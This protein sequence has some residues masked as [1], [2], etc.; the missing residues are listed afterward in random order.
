[1]YLPTI[2]MLLA[3]SLISCQP[4]GKDTQSPDDSALGQNDLGTVQVVMGPEIPTVAHLSWNISQVQTTADIAAQVSYWNSFSDTRTISAQVSDNGDGT[5]S[6]TA[7]LLGL[8]ASSTYD[9]QVEVTEAGVQ[10]GTATG[11][12]ST[13]P[14][15][16]ELP[17]IYVEEFQPGSWQ[18]GYLLSTWVTWPPSVFVVNRLGSYVW[19]IVEDDESED[20]TINT[21]I[22]SN[23]GNSILYALYTSNATFAASDDEDTADAQIV[24]ISLDG[25]E[26]ES[27]AAPYLHHDFTELPDGTLAWLAYDFHEEGNNEYLGDAIMELAPGAVEPTMLWSTW[28]VPEIATTCI[29]RNMTPHANFLEY[30]AERDAYYVSLHNFNAII[31]IQ[32][33]TAQL[34]WTLGGPLSDFTMSEQDEFQW[35]HGFQVLEDTS[36]ILVFD[37]RDFRTVSESDEPVL[38]RVIEMELDTTDMTAQATWEYI[39]DPGFL[40]ICFGDVTRFGSG[41]TLVDFGCSGQ[42]DE[43]DHDGNLLW[44]ATSMAGG[45]MGYHVFKE[46]LYQP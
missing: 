4:E 5:A 22:F 38:S 27:I 40:T 17:G 20:T 36:D 2:S 24:R 16:Q 39:P 28:N 34:D 46:D 26:S 31:K 18:D 29:Q 19:W 25:K 13:D 14:P 33:S 9:F 44:R 42:V 15:P 32:R 3:A 23:D 43:V 37:D 45:A 41:N 6:C 12:L 21:A 35:Q 10:L 8:S 1:M 7:T 11:T 30:S